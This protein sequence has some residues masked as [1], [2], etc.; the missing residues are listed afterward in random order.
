MSIRRLPSKINFLWCHGRKETDMYIGLL[1]YK[2]PLT[3]THIDSKVAF[4]PTTNDGNEYTWHWEQL[5]DTGVDITLA[6]ER[7]S[8]VGAINFTASKD[9]IAE[10]YVLADGRVVGRY[11]ASGN[12][13]FGGRITIPIG[14]RA[15]C[16]TVRL[17]ADFQ[18]IR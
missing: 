16:L 12:G 9:S 4:D 5:F 13:L 6:L 1:N 15:W 18:N 8:Y 14:V 11:Q 3:F 2:Q 7:E 17:H 10:A